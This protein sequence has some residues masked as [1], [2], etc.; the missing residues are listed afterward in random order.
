MSSMAGV[1]K[2]LRRRVVEF[3]RMHRFQKSDFIN[4]LAKM[5]QQLGHPRTTI[6]MLLERCLLSEQ[7]RYP[8]DEREATSFD[9]RFRAS[10]TVEF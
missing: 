8:L 9:Q 4:H 6:T 10:L 1:H 2:E 3:V 5:W 7:F